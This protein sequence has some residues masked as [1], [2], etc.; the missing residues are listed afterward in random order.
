[1]ANAQARLEGFTVKNGYARN[2]KR[3]GGVCIENQG[4]V[5]VACRLTGNHAPGSGISGGGL[6]ILSDL[7]RAERCLIDANDA[8]GNGTG[9]GGGVY[10]T[11]GILSNCLVISNTASASGGVYAAGGTVVNCTIVG[12]RQTL[13]SSTAADAAVGGISTESSATVVNCVVAGNTALVAPTE[14]NHFAPETGGVSASFSHC[15]VAAPAAAPGTGG[16]SAEDCGFANAADGDW[17]LR[18][19]SDFYKK[20]VVQNWMLSATDFAGGPRV[21]KAGLVDLGCFETPY[22]PSATII[23]LF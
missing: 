13:A 19:N 23:L 3:G 6:A 20:G 15:G 5:V 18:R 17:R 4:G 9:H 22:V 10:M 2:G 7:G 16:I 14:G 12:N 21:T 8:S 1:M 11:K